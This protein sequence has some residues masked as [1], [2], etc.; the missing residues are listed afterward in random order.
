MAKSNETIG[1]FGAVTLSESEYILINL[2]LDI[3]HQLP[4]SLRI[5]FEELSSLSP[6][7]ALEAQH[8]DRRNRLE[9]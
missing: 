7:G 8:A 3:Q 2:G 1:T 9:K 4:P 5:V 6:C